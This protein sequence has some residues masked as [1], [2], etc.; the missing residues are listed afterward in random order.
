M[1]KI[2]IKIAFTIIHVIVSLFLRFLLCILN[3]NPTAAT[4]KD[5]FTSEL[6]KDI[7]ILDGTII[8]FDQVLLNYGNH[9]HGDYGIFLCPSNAWFVFSWSLQ[10]VQGRAKAELVM[11][12]TTKIMGPFTDGSEHGSSTSSLSTVIQC[13]EG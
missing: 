6:S 9:Y 10:T 11:D 7:I 12:G 3:F 4:L 5:G 2:S 1:E 13:S 8:V